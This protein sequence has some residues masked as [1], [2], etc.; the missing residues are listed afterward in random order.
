MP[1][2]ILS[3]PL[4][5]QTF[6]RYLLI[7][8]LLAL[9][10]IFFSL[11]AGLIPLL[12]M[13]VPGTISAFFVLTGLRCAMVAKGHMVA[14]TMSAM[15]RSSVMFCIIN[16]MVMYVVGIITIG[17]LAVFGGLQPSGGAG[18]FSSN[19][20]WALVTMLVM[21]L[22]YG[23]YGAMMA[24]PMTAAV[25]NSDERTDTALFFGLGTG[26]VSLTVI[27]VLWVMAGNALS[28]FGEV[29]TIFL[30]MISTLFSLM[31]GEGIT[32][33]WTGGTVSL[34]IRAIMMTWLSAWFYATAVLAWEK[35]KE[36]QTAV[37]SKAMQTNRVSTDSL[38][39]LREER[40][41]MQR[42]GA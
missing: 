35:A 12:S 34:L 23:I 27:V 20:T 42:G 5:F 11:A 30:L 2:L 31:R 21:A 18:G 6:W 3:L 14:P 39:A 9:F 13:L 28:F 22:I 29:T 25:A 15:L 33:A 17:L 1:L 4:S 41:Q 26:A 7:I 24:V 40:A 16:I 32:D 10:A 19:T 38:R 8:P 37:Q 36:R